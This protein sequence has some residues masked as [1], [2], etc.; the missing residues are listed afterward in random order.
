MS[1][2]PERGK[3]NL[4]DYASNNPIS[5]SDL[6][7]MDDDDCPGG[8]CDD[9]GGD[10]DDGG[11]GLEDF[12][13]GDFQ[14]QLQP[15]RTP[16]DTLGLVSGTVG[17]DGSANVMTASPNNT[18]TTCT[19]PATFRGVGGDQAQ[20]PGALYSRF[21]AQ[22]GGSIQGGTFG[23]VAVQK[24]FLGLNRR[25]LRTF[26]TQ[27]FIA[28]GDQGLIARYHGPTGPL[29]VSDYGDANIQTTPG[30]AFDIYRFPTRAAAVQFG[31][32]TM[33]TTIT[34]PNAS[35]GACPPGFSVGP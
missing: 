16:G 29:S 22:T 20:D 34:F 4:F 35:G 5:G 33:N 28:P 13:D 18:T 14:S 12:S 24:N 7:G 23:T 6:S 15:L 17:I 19:G 3:A 26:G 27:I 9:G 11:G 21:P 30:T 1:E 10:G 25:Q 8:D 2:D 32:P 31:K